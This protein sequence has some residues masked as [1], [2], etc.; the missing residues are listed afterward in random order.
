M[1]TLLRTVI[2]LNIL[3]I[4]KI[5]N[6]KIL[7]ILLLGKD[8][9]Y[10]SFISS[11]YNSGLLPNLRLLSRLQNPRQMHNMVKMRLK[12][13]DKTQN[14]SS[15]FYQ[16]N[17]KRQRIGYRY[18]PLIFII[19]VILSPF[20]HQSFHSFIK[21][22]YFKKTFNTIFFIGVNTTNSF[23]IYQH[24]RH[25]VLPLPRAIQIDFTSTS[26]NIICP[27]YIRSKFNGYIIY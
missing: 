9:Y 8:F 21:I 15:I 18:Y 26:I 7:N 25:L 12:K 23:S 2:A 27:T 1:Q 10:N 13:I 5:G 22:L 11:I 3:S 4:F 17:L 24:H 16:P 20:S 6:L 14:Q 19:N